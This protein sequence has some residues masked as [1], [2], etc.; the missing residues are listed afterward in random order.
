MNRIV[1]KFARLK[2]EG[3]KGFI[4]YIGAGDPNLEVTRHLALAL[5][6]A[7]VDVPELGVPF[8]DP[9]AAGLVN[10]RAAQRA[11][12]SGTPPPKVLET[13]AAIRNESQLPVV[14]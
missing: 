13:V 14:L 7:G 12:E 3:K 5:D 11:L 1:E 8:S 9:R 10:Q 2:R 6:R 4:I